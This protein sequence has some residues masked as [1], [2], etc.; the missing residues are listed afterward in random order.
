MNCYLFK[1]E[2]LVFESEGWGIIIDD[3]YND[4]KYKE[5]HVYATHQAC[6]KSYQP[7]EKYGEGVPY[8]Y[9]EVCWEPERMKKEGR[10]VAECFVCQVA[11]PEGVQA[12]IL[13]QAWDNREGR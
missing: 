7:Y 5:G 9:G 8:Q 2:R 12:L 3:K 13:M 10:T 6:T 4:R 11:V 1:G